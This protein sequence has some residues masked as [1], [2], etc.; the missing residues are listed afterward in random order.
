[1]KRRELIR[2]LKLAGFTFTRHGANHDVYVRGNEIEEVPRHNEIN[3]NLA[4]MI[5]KKRNLK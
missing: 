1:M 5:I 2:L 4:K 3:E